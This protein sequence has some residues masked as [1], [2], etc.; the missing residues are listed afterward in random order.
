MYNSQHQIY[1]FFRYVLSFLLYKETLI[2]KSKK[3]ARLFSR[4]FALHF[5]F[6]YIQ[7][8]SIIVTSEF[9]L[10]KEVAVPLIGYL[11][12]LYS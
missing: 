9:E 2:N 12:S 7:S 6:I 11:L 4:A 10:S 8:Y 5:N 3:K 1:K